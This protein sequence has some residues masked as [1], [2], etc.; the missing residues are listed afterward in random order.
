MWGE[1]E[2]NLVEFEPGKNRLFRDLWLLYH[3]DLKASNRVRVMREF[4]A[5][6][7][8]QTFGGPDNPVPPLLS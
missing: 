2:P 5:D 8:A 7:A 1:A 3:R 6:V 4:L